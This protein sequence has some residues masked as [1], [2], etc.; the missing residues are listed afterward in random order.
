M[1]L[2]DMVTGD[3]NDY[4]NIFSPSRSIFHPQLFCNALESA[5]NLLSFRK[6]R[7]T[8]LGCALKWNPLE[9]TWDCPCHGSR[10]AK[11]G[12]VIDNPATKDLS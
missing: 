7:C 9:R 5:V 4:E 6:K 11:E 2:S 12:A 3:K 10:F 1:I 8:H